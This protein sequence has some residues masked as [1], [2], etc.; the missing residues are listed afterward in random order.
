MWAAC[1]VHDLSYEAHMRGE[2]MGSSSWEVDKK[3][4]TDMGR[5]IAKENQWWKKGFMWGQRI[6]YFSLVRV[7]GTFRW[8]RIRNQSQTNLSTL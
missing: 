4:W 8:S 6:V 3:F 2:D 7:V 5:L 1:K